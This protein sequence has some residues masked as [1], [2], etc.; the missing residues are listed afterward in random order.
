MIGSRK[1]VVMGGSAGSLQALFV[2]LDNLDKEFNIPILIVL[3]RVTSSDTGL[4]DVLATKTKLSVVEIEE[5]D[6]ITE[7]YVYICPADYHVLV[8][9]DG[10]F[11]LDASEKVNF[12]RPSIDVVFSAVA[13]VFQNN[14]IAVLLSGANA[15]GTSGLMAVRE[16]KG[17]VIVQDPADAQVPFM[18]EHALKLL[19][20]DQLL[21]AKDIARYLNDLCR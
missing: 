18:P 3:H 21:P 11:A 5:K 12:S 14:T 10:T 4:Q 13:D 2:I 16:K 1:L 15:D 9:P 8:E 19:E 17:I 20:P 7:G 6:M